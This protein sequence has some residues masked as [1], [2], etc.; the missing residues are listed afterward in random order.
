MAWCL[1]LLSENIFIYSLMLEML[2]TWCCLIL[3]PIHYHI[4]TTKQK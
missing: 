2:N 1:I 3:I 4:L